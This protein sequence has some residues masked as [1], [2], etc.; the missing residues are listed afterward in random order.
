MKVVTVYVMVSRG[1]SILRVKGR[2]SCHGN[3]KSNEVHTNPIV[4]LKYF[5]HI[6]FWGNNTDRKKDLVLVNLCSP[7]NSIQF[8]LGSTHNSRVK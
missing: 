6:I 8:Y 5:Y 7:T 2:G 1:E 3:L 4:F